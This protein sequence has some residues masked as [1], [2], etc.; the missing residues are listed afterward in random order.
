MPKI[1][2]IHTADLHL[3][4]PFKGISELDEAISQ[5]L[6]DATFNAF[7]N[8]IN[9]CIE[10]KVDFLL[11]SGDVYD[12]Q[13]KSLRAQLKF[14]DGLGRLSKEGIQTY[15]VHGNHDPSNGWASNL[16]IPMNVH[17]FGGRKVHKHIFQ[18]DGEDL[19]EI[20]GFSYHRRDITDSVIPEF[21]EK[22]SSSTLFSIA[23]LHCNLSTSTE[24]EPYA[25][26]AV[27]DL[28]GL[29]IDY[30][31]LG[32]VHN[33]DIVKESPMI[34]Y[35]GNTQGRHIREG[36]ERGCYLVE[37]DDNHNI[38]MEFKP[39]ACIRWQT[40][41]LSIEGYKNIQELMREIYKIIDDIKEE[42]DNRPAI[43]RLNLTGR[44]A[45]S[46][47][48]MRQSNIDDILSELRD[49]ESTETCFVW[50][51]KIKVETSSPIDREKLRDSGDFIGEIVGMYDE[52]YEKETE[53]QK[54]NEALQPLF[55]SRRGM[56]Y[57]EIID[58][59]ELLELIKNAELLSIDLLMGEDG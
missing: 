31:A 16:E 57:L 51:E 39:T 26:C 2:F 47:D 18:K 14:I 6:A 29:P 55:D 36:G 8:I 9:L 27:N 33:M 7:E 59:D 1:R 52:L 30:W 5:E 24:H 11:I 41:N 12:N 28:T 32:H 4:S 54:L 40:K 37:V 46:Q 48:L 50:V 34:V 43:C 22:V 23:L 45:L 20:Y 58:D 10:E 53:R 42:C 25:P 19:A 56:K 44:G 15:V 17:V 3:D 49:N 21:E 38:K 35:P 13:D